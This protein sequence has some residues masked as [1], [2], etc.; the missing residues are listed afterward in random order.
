MD[1]RLRDERRGER[2]KKI[3]DSRMMESE[4]YIHT[5]GDWSQPS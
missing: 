5:L 1:G 4:I 3:K 2:R